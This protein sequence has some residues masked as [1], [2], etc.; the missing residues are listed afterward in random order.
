[1]QTLS[2]NKHDWDEKIPLHLQN[3]W[4]KLYLNLKSLDQVR[5]PRWYGVSSNSAKLQLIGFCDASLAAYSALVYNRV[6]TADQEIKVN[7]AMAKSRVAP[8]HT[9]SIPRMELSV[10]HLLSNTLLYVKES[11]KVKIG[12]IIAYSYP[13]VT[14][15]WLAKP[16]NTWNV[17]DANKV[18][19][20]Q[21]KTPEIKWGY[22]KLKKI[23][24]T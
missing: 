2:V 16:A 15:D 22:V 3:D 14:L 19:E 6:T 9:V 17:F 20:I 12:E 10:A 18:P 4:E 7:F 24:Q 8:V 1:M 21:E 13:K 23:S 5:I 11:L